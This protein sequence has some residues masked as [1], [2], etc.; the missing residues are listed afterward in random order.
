MINIA[1]ETMRNDRQID[2]MGHLFNLSVAILKVNHYRDLFPQIIPG[3][4]SGRR[5]SFYYLAAVNANDCK[6][7]TFMQQ[8]ADNQ[9][10]I[11]SLVNLIKFLES[12]RAINR[13]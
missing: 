11:Y 2:A 9:T 1:R 6:F 4:P 12:D 7:V 8:P 5:F 10:L 3:L 13:K